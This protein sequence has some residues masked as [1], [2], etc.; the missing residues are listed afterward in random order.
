VLCRPYSAGILHS[1]S[2]QMQ[3]LPNYS[4][5]PNK[6]TSENDIKG[7]V[8][9]K[10][11]RSCCY[12]WRSELFKIKFL[13]L[14]IGT[15]AESFPR[16][17]QLHYR[18]LT[19][20][21]KGAT[22]PSHYTDCSWRLVRTPRFSYVRTVNKYVQYTQVNLGLNQLQ[23]SLYKIYHFSKAVFFNFCGPA[24]CCKSN[25]NKVKE[26]INTQI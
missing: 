7:L 14:S 25:P 26:A 1:V 24:S 2:D 8:S 13:H 21:A 10:F 4:T 23:S 15:A 16:R 5:T 3:N 6:M 20:V 12:Q 17:W 19:G 11:L 22:M 9:L 18:Y